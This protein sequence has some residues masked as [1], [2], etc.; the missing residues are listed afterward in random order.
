MRRK[1]AAADIIRVINLINY[2]NSQVLNVNEQA[3]INAIFRHTTDEGEAGP[4]LSLEQIAHEASISPASVSR[5]IK[6]AGYASFEDFRT[7]FSRDLEQVYHRRAFAHATVYG[8][9]TKDIFETIYQNAIENLR[10]TYESLDHD[11]LWQ[12]VRLMDNA[13]TVV[14]YGDEH[15]LAD[16]YTLQL[17]LMARGV[18]TFLFKNEEMQAMQAQHVGEGDVVLFAAVAST[19]VRPDQR[20]LLE[21]L[22]RLD[23]VTSIGLCQDDEGVSELF[24]LFYPFGQP[25]TLN[26][27]YHSLWLL[28]LL[29]SEM[30]YEL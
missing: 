4:I 2:C 1:R 14:I 15:A 5:F 28:S 10:A 25:G 8:G 24:D 29:M 9:G 17:D 30:L 21:G 7:S 13:R 20:L 12:I 23:G 19:F 26:D 22:H 16:L 11:L 18:A 3:I 27:G 6:K